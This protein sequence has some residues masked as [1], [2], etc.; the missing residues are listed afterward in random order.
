MNDRE[1]PVDF[2]PIKIDFGRAVELTEEVVAEKGED[3]VYR[4]ECSYV[5]V[6]DYNKVPGCIVGQVLHKAGISIE[7]LGIL[8][9][10][11]TS[12][13]FTTVASLAHAGILDLDDKTEMF[14]N[15]VQEMQ[16][17]QE[18]YGAALRSAKIDAASVSTGRDH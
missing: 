4:D 7:V 8:D 15:T 12:G 13:G 9:E 6:N 14:L 16:D 18:Q 2:E 17:G 10:V 5:V 1:S 11:V 3:F